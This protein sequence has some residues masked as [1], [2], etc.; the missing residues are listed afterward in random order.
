MVPNSGPA[1][2]SVIWKYTENA[3]TLQPESVTA[4]ANIPPGSVTA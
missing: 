1:S 2:K 3:V 4:Q